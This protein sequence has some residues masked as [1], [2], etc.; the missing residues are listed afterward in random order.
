MNRAIKQQLNDLPDGRPAMRQLEAK[1]GMFVKQ[2]TDVVQKAADN[3][4]DAN[5]HGVA[6]FNISWNY[7]TAKQR[8]TMNTKLKID[9][10]AHLPGRNLIQA[11]MGKPAPGIVKYIYV[12]PSFDFVGAPIMGQERVYPIWINPTTNKVVQS[13]VADVIGE[14]IDYMN[15]SFEEFY[16]QLTVDDVGPNT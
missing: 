1:E 12:H 10:V 16:R 15:D 6:Y 4:Q 2:L 3:I 11:L 9:V 7:G 14:I 13:S 5:D 8:M